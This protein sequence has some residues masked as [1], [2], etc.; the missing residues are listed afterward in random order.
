MGS[1][2]GSP[3]FWKL[4]FVRGLAEDE[5][6]ANLGLGVMVFFMGPFRG[7]G[8]RVLCRGLGFLGCRGLGFWGLGFRGLWFAGLGG[9]IPL[10]PTHKSLQHETLNLELH[11]KP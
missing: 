1:I 8:L 7:L 2:F 9:L 4:P 11:P 6:T 3:Y 5:G 10:H